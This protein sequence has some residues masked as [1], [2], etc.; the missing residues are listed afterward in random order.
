M[1][2]A[3]REPSSLVALVVILALAAIGSALA[4]HFILPCG[5]CSAHWVAAPDMHDARMRHTATLLPNGTVLVAG[6]ASV[7]ADGYVSLASAEIYDP[8]TNSWRRTGSLRTAR[9]GHTATLLANGKV[10]VVGG[11]DGYEWLS[12]ADLY[13]PSTE[14]W[15]PAASMAVSRSSHSATLLAN[16]KVLVAGGVGSFSYYGYTDSAE[17]YDPV[18]DTWTPA[19]SLPLPHADHTAT[20]MADGRVLVAGGAVEFPGEYPQDAEVYDPVSNTWTSAGT[21]GE[22]IDPRY[23]SATLLPNGKAM[24]AGGGD[25]TDW[26]LDGIFLYDP[27]TNSWNPGGRLETVRLGH[28]ASLLPSGDV[29]IAGGYD[30][31]GVAASSE[32]YDVQNGDSF[33]AADLVNARAFHTATVLPNG[34]VLIAGGRN[35]EGALA[36]TELYV[37]DMRRARPANRN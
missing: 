26:V 31:E 23:S 17:L 16:G 15:G 1:T 11:D 7:S 21:L 24:L 28:S 2:R 27:A 10:L 30:Y 18:S 34:M 8:A 14:T 33:A 5:D 29:L 36:S 35:I 3:V 9:E 32:I 20:L 22:P 12:S 25:A 6:G 19:A 13:D 37:A 4:N